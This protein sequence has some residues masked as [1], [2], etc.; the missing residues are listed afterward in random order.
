MFKKVKT[1]DN[2]KV[3]VFRT[4]TVVRVRQADKNGYVSSRPHHLYVSNKGYYFARIN[5][6]YTGIRRNAESNR[7]TVV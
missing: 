1:N 6:E 2:K 3:S 7:W 5:G 4:G